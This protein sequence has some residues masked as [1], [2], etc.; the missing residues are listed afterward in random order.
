[1]I[2]LTCFAEYSYHIYKGIYLFTF[3]FCFDA[4]RKFQNT[5]LL[6]HL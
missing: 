5:T 4:L 6:I 3:H 1:M 2:A